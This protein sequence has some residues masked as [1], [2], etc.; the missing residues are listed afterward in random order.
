MRKKYARFILW[1][2]LPAV[3]VIASFPI[4]ALSQSE[5]LVIGMGVM[6]IVIFGVSSVLLSK[7]TPAIRK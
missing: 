5:L 6:L 2:V 7:K 1:T 4:F 3:A